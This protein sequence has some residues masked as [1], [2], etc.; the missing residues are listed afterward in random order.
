MQ[1][2]IRNKN[3]VTLYSA[4]ES[5]WEDTVQNYC[6]LRRV[7]KFNLK[8]MFQILNA[9]STSKQKRMPDFYLHWNLTLKSFGG[10]PKIL[11][12]ARPYMNIRVHFQKH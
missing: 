5:F 6:T 10:G 9:L 4:N 12:A 1:E 2:Q 7:Q 3:Y 8:T 11:H